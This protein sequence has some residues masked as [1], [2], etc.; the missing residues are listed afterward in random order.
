MTPK[1]PM[2]FGAACAG[3]FACGRVVVLT[4]CN[5][6]LAPV[7][8]FAANLGWLFTEHPFLDRFAAA[9]AAGF[10]AVEFAS[11]YEHPAEAIA[12]RLA[13]NDLRCILFNLPMGDK[14]KGDFGIACR[15]GR[16]EEFR[17]GVARGIAYAQTL[18]CTRVNCIAGRIFA[19]DDRADLEAR[20]VS[21][22]RFAAREFKAAGIELVIEPLNDQDNP[23]FLLPRQRQVAKVIEE[24]GEPNVGLQLDI[25]HV[26][27][28]GDDP[29]AL[30]EELRPIIRHVQFADVPGRGE[31][32][33]GRIDLPSLFA[34]LD[35]L[36]YDGWVSAEYRPSLQTEETLYWLF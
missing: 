24:I 31:P 36:G 2:G 10:K 15:P 12:E 22:L 30:I 6:I 17:E 33:T 11:P 14:S 34:L 26:V 21:N 16:E 20:L 19:G 13:R 8:N 7:P 27:M 5:A 32:G 29:A 1:S 25:Y 9:S 28:M 23:N 18:A 3:D 4:D 35:R